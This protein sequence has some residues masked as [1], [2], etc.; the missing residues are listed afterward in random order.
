MAGHKKPVFKPPVLKF[1]RKISRILD[2]ERFVPYFYK[3]KIVIFCK[4]GKGVFLD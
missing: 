3:N 2:L 4:V 1:G